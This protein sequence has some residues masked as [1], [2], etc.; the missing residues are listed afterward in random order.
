VECWQHFTARSLGSL[1]IPPFPLASA[2][3]QGSGMAHLAASGARSTYI[4]SSRAS[5]SRVGA[6]RA[7]GSAGLLAFGRESGSWKTSPF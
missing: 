7:I 4:V 5:K 2:G 3:G 6:L 1:R